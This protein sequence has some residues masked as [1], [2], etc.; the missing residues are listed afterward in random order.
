MQAIIPLLL[1]FRCFPLDAHSSHPSSSVSPLFF[2]EPT[3]PYG[4][5]GKAASSAGKFVKEALKDVG[6]A[7]KGIFTEGRREGKVGRD[8]NQSE[9]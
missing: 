3:I 9:S 8:M 4:Q 2:S 5:T 1:D 6:D 7:A